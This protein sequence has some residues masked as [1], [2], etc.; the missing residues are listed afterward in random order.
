[1]CVCAW[2][3]AP[4]RWQNFTHTGTNSVEWR[5]YKVGGR[6]LRR[7]P[8]LR[9]YDHNP[10]GGASV[11]HWPSVTSLAFF[12]KSVDLLLP[13]IFPP[14]AASEKGCCSS[15][16]YIGYTPPTSVCV[17]VYTVGNLDSLYGFTSSFS[18]VLDLWGN[19]TSNR[20]FFFIF[21]FF[22]NK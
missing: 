1:M 3:P 6:W 16:S 10:H 21:F 8:A 11:A 20:N 5:Q 2:I 13:A 22:I 17:C 9:M 15:C 4:P 19:V 12:I 18:S 14:A 7:A